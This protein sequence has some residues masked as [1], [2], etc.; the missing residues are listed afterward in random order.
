MKRII[1]LILVATSFVVFSNVSSA[2]IKPGTTCSPKGKTTIF[3]GFKYTCVLNG[4]RLVWNNGLKIQSV[5]T[6]TTATSTTTTS[7]TTTTTYQTLNNPHNI[8]DTSVLWQKAALQAYNFKETRTSSQLTLKVIQ[9]PDFTPSAFSSKME[10]ALKYSLAYWQGLS[11]KSAVVSIVEVNENDAEWASKQL[12]LL[13]SDGFDS[14]LFKDGKWNIAANAYPSPDLP[15]QGLEEYL[16]S[17]TGIPTFLL[18]LGTQSN[19]GACNGQLTTSC[20][21]LTQSYHNAAHAIMFLLEPTIYA[22]NKLSCWFAEGHPSFYGYALSMANE[23][24]SM[25]AVRAAQFRDGLIGATGFKPPNSADAWFS[26]LKTNETRQD[27]GCFTYSLGYSIGTAMIEKLILDYGP[28][29][30]ND[31]MFFQAA[32]SGEWRKTFQDTFSITLDD[33]YLKSAIPYLIA[34]FADSNYEAKG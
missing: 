32:A 26:F 31:W 14:Y 27:P 5:A 13:G 2:A 6:T 33:W 11:P 17:S 10:D 20:G 16:P 12:T 7:T 15:H 23:S 25:S 30:V 18:F 8:F 9:S 4:K 3:A 21:L 22:N 1:A 24:A 29:K 19:F 28:K 34:T